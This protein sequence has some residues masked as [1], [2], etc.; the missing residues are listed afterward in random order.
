MSL[1]STSAPVV[2]RSPPIASS[3]LATDSD[4]T[5]VGLVSPVAI[6]YTVDA[7]ASA[8]NRMPSGPKARAPADFSG[9]VPFFMPDA[10]SSASAAGT[11]ASVARAARVRKRVNMARSFRTNEERESGTPIIVP[12]G[13]DASANRWFAQVWA[14]HETARATWP[15]HTRPSGYT[16]AAN[17]DRARTGDRHAPDRGHQP[18]GRGGED[19]DG[20]EPGR[21]PGPRGG[22]RLRPRPRPAG[23]R[24]H[25]L[26]GRAGR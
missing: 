3:I 15:I 9:G 23:S 22:T 7:G 2:P 13:P 6:A 12:A 26:R 17:Q 18:E 4:F 19:D 21:G 20:C 16:P 1:I 25:A 8:T 10:A 11:N 5:S 14:K 24:D